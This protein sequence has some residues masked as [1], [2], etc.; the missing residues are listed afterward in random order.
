MAGNRFFYEGQ[1]FEV[2]AAC[3]GVSTLTLAWVGAVLLLALAERE[4]PRDW[5]L[6]QITFWLLLA[7]LLAVGANYIRTFWLVLFH[8]A[9]GT[10][11]HELIGLLAIGLWVIFPLAVLLRGIGTR[12][13]TEATSDTPQPSTP[14]SY[15]WLPI[16]ILGLVSL[17]SLWTWL[18]PDAP[19]PEEMTQIE[20]WGMKGEPVP[21]EVMRFRGKNGLLY[22]KAPASAWRANH[23]PQ[24]CWRGSGYRFA[25]IQETRIGGL[26]AM[27]ALLIHDSD[28]LVTAW[29]YHNGKTATCGVWDWRYRQMQGE[30]EFYLWNIAVEDQVELENLIQG[31]PWER[32][33]LEP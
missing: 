12:S 10:L 6:A 8:S 22:L 11:G 7:T 21:P 13:G 24:I 29:G 31:I 16:L 28:T 27:Q 3:M 26:P 20:I 19:L 9:P 14:G 25:Q 18:R 33:V 1:W 2:K 30:R 23:D 17:G 4:R 15:R 5:T 32:L